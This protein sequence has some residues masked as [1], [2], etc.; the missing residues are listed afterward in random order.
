[1]AN[2][3]P[4]NKGEQVKGG[5]PI[6]ENAQL[7]R[8][9]EAELPERTINGAVRRMTMGAQ[10]ASGTNLMAPVPEHQMPQHGAGGKQA[11]KPHPA[12]SNRHRTR[13]RYACICMS[14]MGTC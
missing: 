10:P 6:I 9:G 8:M 13:G 12:N 3:T 11:Y 14:R 5:P 1:M 2:E 7:P 4:P